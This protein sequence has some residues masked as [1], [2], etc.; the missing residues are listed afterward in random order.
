MK[1]LYHQYIYQLYQ[2]IKKDEYY[3]LVL[4]V[5]LDLNSVVYSIFVVENYSIILPIEIIYL[6][7]KLD[8]FF[9]RQIISAVAYEDKQKVIIIVISNKYITE[10]VRQNHFSFIPFV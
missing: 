2:V 7:N 3:F 8:I 4:K 5:D 9:F 6:E 1:D 10:Y